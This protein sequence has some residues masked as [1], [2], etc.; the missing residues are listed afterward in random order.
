MSE[1]E[2]GVVKW[3]NSSKGFGFIQRDEGSDVFVHYSAISGSGYR[4]LEEGQR[5]EIV[6]AEGP[7][8]PQATSVKVL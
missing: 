3:F 7:K 1:C 8:G 6:V 4:S 2:T 5:V